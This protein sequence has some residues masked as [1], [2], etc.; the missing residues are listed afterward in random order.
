MIEKTSNSPRPH[1]ALK[2][3]ALAFAG[4][5]ALAVAPITVESASA[6]LHGPVNQASCGAKIVQLKFIAKGTTYIGHSTTPSGA[7]AGD[8]WTLR[9]GTTVINTGLSTMFWQMWTSPSGLSQWS[10][11]CVNFG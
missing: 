5:L 10:V 1:R 2:L 4:A 11:Q 7:T 3:S 9:K 8:Y 6:D